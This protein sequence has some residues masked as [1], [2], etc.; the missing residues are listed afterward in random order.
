MRPSTILHLWARLGRSGPGRWLF[1]RLLGRAVPYTGSLGATVERLTPGHAVVVLRDRAGVRNHLHSIHAIALA[2]LGEMASGL[3]M[4]GAVGD[5]VRAI[6]TRLEIDFHAKAR[7]EVRAT[8]SASPPA[9][10]APIDAEALAEIDDEGGV[11]V[12]TVRV[13]WRLAPHEST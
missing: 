2:N 7:G 11:R 4:L 8:G 10:T 13:T 3:A 1:S 6:V 12:A 5:D 9:V